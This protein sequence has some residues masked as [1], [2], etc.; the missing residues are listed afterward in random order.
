MNGVRSLVSRIYIR[1]AG[2]VTSY[3]LNIIGPDGCMAV[4]PWWSGFLR[5]CQQRGPS[6]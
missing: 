4:Y 2:H 5:A 1:G 3:G 6:L